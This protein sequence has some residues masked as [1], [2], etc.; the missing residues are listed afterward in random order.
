VF[1]DDGRFGNDYADSLWKLPPRELLEG[2]VAGFA[3]A[4]D[5][6]VGLSGRKA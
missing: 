4:W 3:R 5:T 1:S 2:G 6:A